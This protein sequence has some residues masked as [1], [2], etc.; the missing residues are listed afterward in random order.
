MFHQQQGN[1]EVHC[2]FFYSRPFRDINQSPLG[3][4]ILE[5]RHPS[6]NMYSNDQIQQQ[7]AS[8]KQQQ[9]FQQRL[10]VEQF[11]QQQQQMAQEHE[12]QLQEHIKVQQVQEHIKMQQ[13]LVMLQKQQEFLQEQQKLQERHR[14]EKE[15]MEKERL[16]QLKNK[17]K[18]EESAVASSEVKLRLQEFVLTKKHREAAA[19]NS[20]PFHNWVV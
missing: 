6:A 17:T 16:E 18:N 20:P 7:I 11:R 2:P 8:L 5:R 10:L 15:R 19:R 13:H 14:L 3:S 12:K 1:S 4:P 9:E